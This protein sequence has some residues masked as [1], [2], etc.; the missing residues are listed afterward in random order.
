MNFIKNYFNKSY[1]EII[2][3]FLM[4][5]IAIVLFSNL[6]TKIINFIQR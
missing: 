4:A 2:I 1:T 3:D 6:C 5:F